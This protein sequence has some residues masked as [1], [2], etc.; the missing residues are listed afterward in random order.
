LSLLLSAFVLAVSLLLVIGCQW[1][2][3]HDNPFDPNYTIHRPSLKLLVS[4]SVLRSERAIPNATV[5]I[6]S[7]G[8]YTQTDSTGW[9]VFNDMPAGDWW[10]AAYREGGVLPI[11]A[12]D[13]IL[14]TV[15][16]NVPTYSQIHLDALPHFERVFVNQMTVKLRVNNTIQQMRLKAYIED[17]DGPTDL[18]AVKWQF[19]E[20]SGSLSYNQDPD[21]AFWETII[22]SA[23]FPENNI[24]VA[25]SAPFIFEAMDRDSN[26][27]RTEMQLVRIFTDVPR[28]ENPTPDRR[29]HFAWYY[30]WTRYFPTV[31]DFWYRI[32]IFNE[33]TDFMV[34]DTLLTP[35]QRHDPWH[36][37]PYD[38]DPGNYFSYL[39]VIDNFGNYARTEKKKIQ[40]LP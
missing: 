15:N 30:E 14:V 27:V 31:D 5:T 24:G 38:L 4:G 32:V 37:V 25:L 10:V 34:Y 18:M 12:P 11:Y 33:D 7:L 19:Q 20:M 35:M 26:T 36:D 23:S 28:F 17:A 40:I 9:A 29:P 3:P 22:P 21:S 6:S 2:P 1:D 8:R 39:Y 16:V 13:S